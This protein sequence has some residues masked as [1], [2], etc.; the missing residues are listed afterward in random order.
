VVKTIY[1]RTCACGAKFSAETIEDLKKAHREHC[2]EV[3]KNPDGK[4]HNYV[5][6]REEVEVY[7]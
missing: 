6:W 7:E 1:Y 2:L 5:D 3:V 4:L